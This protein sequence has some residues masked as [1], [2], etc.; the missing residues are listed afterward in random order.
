LIVT[1]AISEP[2]EQSWALLKN[3]S[4]PVSMFSRSALIANSAE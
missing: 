1:E 2:Y 4:T 3:G